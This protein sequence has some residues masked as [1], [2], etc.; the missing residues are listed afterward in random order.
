MKM[1][2]DTARTQMQTCLIT[3][4]KTVLNIVLTYTQA[5]MGRRISNTALRPIL[6]CKTS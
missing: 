6:H 2:S 3:L 5:I 4:P 1:S